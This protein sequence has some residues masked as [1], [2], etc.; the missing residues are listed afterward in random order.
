MRVTAAIP[1]YNAEKY[2][3]AA[4]ISV[5]EQSYPCDECLVIDDGST[6]KTREIATSFPFVRYVYQANG[7]DANARNRAI[8]E[9]SGDLIAFL[10]SDDVWKPEKLHRQVEVFQALPDVGMVYTGVEVVDDQLNHVETLRPAPAELA[11]RNTLLVEKPYMT[12]VGSSGLVRKE[13]AR[14]VGFDERL[15]ASAD[16]AFACRVALHHEVAPVDEALVLYRQHADSQVHLN[17][18]AVEADMTLTWG[19]LFQ[20]PS[21][22]HPIVRRRRRA[23]AN[24]YLSLAAS[25]FKK[26]DRPNFLR[27]LGKACVTRPDRLA[28]ALWRRYMGAPR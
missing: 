1:A 20:D 13:I 25:Y 15:R 21:L 18:R 3:A 9:A 16:W 24:L 10:D 11:L 6:D 17:L 2:L 23:L 19:E 7:G 14:Q 28:A 26:G 8:N 22:P 4:L 5:S 12:G 27:Y